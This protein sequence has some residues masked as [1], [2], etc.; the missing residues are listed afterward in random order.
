VEI[1]KGPLTRRRISSANIIPHLSS[2]SQTRAD[3]ACGGFRG[4]RLD[5]LAQLA[6]HPTAGLITEQGYEEQAQS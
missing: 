6:S 1:A 2:T 5:I 3:I 4:I